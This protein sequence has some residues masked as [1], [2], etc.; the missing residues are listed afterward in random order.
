M[1]TVVTQYRITKLYPDPV[2]GLSFGHGDDFN[3]LFRYFTVSTPDPKSL[4]LPSRFLFEIHH[5]FASALHFF[6]IEEK[7]AKGWPKPH[8]GTL[9]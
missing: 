9:S 2:S 6:F 4:P 3:S 5:R 1:L 7:I 8:R